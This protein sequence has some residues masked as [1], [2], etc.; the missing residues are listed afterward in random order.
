MMRDEV[1][2]VCEVHSA[3]INYFA[4]VSARAYKLRGTPSDEVVFWK[5]RDPYNHLLT[6]GDTWE[7]PSTG[8]K[9]R[10]VEVTNQFHPPT[11]FGS[12]SQKE[13]IEHLILE[14]SP[15]YTCRG[16]NATLL[17]TL[18]ID[19][20]TRFTGE[21]SIELDTTKLFRVGTA[22]IVHKVL[23]S[24]DEYSKK[25]VFLIVGLLASQVDMPKYSINMKW[26]T[27]HLGTVADA[28]DTYVMNIT[29]TVNASS[30]RLRFTPDIKE[31]AAL[32]SQYFKTA[33]VSSPTS[34]QFTVLPRRPSLWKRF[35]NTA[36][37]KLKRNN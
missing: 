36:I 9:R 32:A 19:T 1:S 28:D 12:V 37:S 33:L 14:S 18:D 26:Q 13:K 24:V 27:T 7:V 5:H 29:F 30:H 17:Y 21:W 31:E 22:Y 15:L 4:D 34:S 8:N 6:Q 23:R 2:D 25:A 11:Q 35:R 10:I 16:D 3:D 20:S